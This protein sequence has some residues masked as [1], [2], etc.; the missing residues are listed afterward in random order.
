MYAARTYDGE[1]MGK[2]LGDTAHH[3][4]ELF[5]PY[6]LCFSLPSCL[7]AETWIWVWFR[8]QHM[9]NITPCSCQQNVH[10]AWQHVAKLVGMVLNSYLKVAPLPG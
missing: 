3:H 1:L 6:L 7:R 4:G 9:T 10:S 5:L 2:N 8:A